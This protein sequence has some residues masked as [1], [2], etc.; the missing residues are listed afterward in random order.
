MANLFDNDRFTFDSKLQSVISGSQAVVA[1][2][3]ACEGFGS[4]HL[5]PLISATRAL[6][7][8]GSFASAAAESSVKV[9]V[10]MM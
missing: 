1:R 2:Q 8:L 6:I 4:A 10:G 5:R 3:I 9:T 7:G